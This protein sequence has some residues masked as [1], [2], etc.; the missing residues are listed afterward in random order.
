MFQAVKP[1]GELISTLPA[2]P[3]YPGKTAGASFE[4]FY[5]SDCLLPHRD[6][7]WLLLTERILQAATFCGQTLSGA[8]GPVADR[9]R[10]V[11][12]GLDGIARFLA[13]HM[14]AVAAR[15]QPAW[16]WG[17]AGPPAETPA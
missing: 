17:P 13:A 14:P 12:D 7:A 15:P 10:V 9:L 4:L 1:L 6:A 16:D 5:E 3:E 8:P 2:G 11:R